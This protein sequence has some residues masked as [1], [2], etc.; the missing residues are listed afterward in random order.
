MVYM[1]YN[2]PAKPAI[3]SV[4]HGIASKITFEGHS[5]VIWRQNLSDCIVH[6]PNCECRIKE[7]K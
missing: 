5:Y 6:D 1:S 7:E 2:E 3:E 4:G